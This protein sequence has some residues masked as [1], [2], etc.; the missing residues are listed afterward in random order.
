M[1]REEFLSKQADSE[2]RISWRVLPLGVIYFIRLISLVASM[3]LALLL[4]TYFA[5]DARKIILFEAVFCVLL[6]VGSFVAERHGTRQ[7]ARLGL[8]CSYCQGFLVFIDGK[9][10]AATGCCPHCGE[11]VFTVS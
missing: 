3:I 6:F 4:W 5:T 11:R 10:A 9:K 1:T 7:F 2:R 8:R